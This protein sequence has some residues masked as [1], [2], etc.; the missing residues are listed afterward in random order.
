MGASRE[1]RAASEQRLEG[2]RQARDE[3]IKT[4]ESELNVAPAEL[5]AL[6]GLASGEATPEAAGV[7]RKLESLKQERE[8]LG[9]VNLRADEELAEVT[10]S[11][12]RLVAERDDLTEAIKR[13]RQAIHNL[14]QEGRERLLAAFEVV[15]KPFRR[16]VRDFVRGRH[17]RAATD[18]IRRSARG[19][20]RTRRA[21]AGQES[22]RR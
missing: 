21:S 12:D 18:R 9:A 22:R 20:A 16:I 11:R 10:A 2:A 7:E 6:A 19:R 15:N 4:I 17:G 5:P 1:A 8:R 3:L 14:N 13:L